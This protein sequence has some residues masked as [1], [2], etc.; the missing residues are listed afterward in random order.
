MIVKKTSP[1]DK[2]GKKHSCLPVGNNKA[3]EAVS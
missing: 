2:S 3:I 1:E